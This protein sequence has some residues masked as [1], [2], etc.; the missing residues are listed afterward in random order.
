MTN[1]FPFR[2][3]FGFM[4]LFGMASPVYCSV[5]K[6]KSMDVYGPKWGCVLPEALAG[7]NFPVRG[8]KTLLDT[9]VVIRSY[10]P[11]LAC[12]ALTPQHP[13]TGQR[14]SCLRWSYA[15]DIRDKGR[16]SWC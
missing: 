10:R 1:G 6:F 15:N 4:R 2:S 14:A 8:N 5:T 9:R 16:L 7:N 12:S 3:A 11:S 13:A